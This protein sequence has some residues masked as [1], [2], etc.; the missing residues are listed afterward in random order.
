MTSSTTLRGYSTVARVLRLSDG[1]IL[2]WTLTDR[3]GA[4]HVFTKLDGWLGTPIRVDKNPMWQDG[5]HVGQL[6]R[7]GRPLTIAGFHRFCDA[8]NRADEAERLRR[9]ISGAFRS[10]QSGDGLV[11]VTEESTGISLEAHNVQLDGAPRFRVDGTDGDYMVTWE[12]PLF[13]GDPLLYE[14][15]QTPF[16]AQLYTP[17]AD[18]GLE[19]ALF[20]DADG[21]T[22]GFL[23][24]TGEKDVAVVPLTNWG[25]AVAYPQVTVQG[26]FPSGFRLVL[27]GDGPALRDGTRAPWEVTYRGEVLPS[28]EVTVDMS[29]MLLID[30]IDQSWAVSDPHW[31][32]VEPGG[33]V[34]GKL[35]GVAGGLGQATMTLTPAYI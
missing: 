21:V 2:D 31:G 17:G 3:P 9:A 16:L 25:N 18:S 24:F 19:Y 33:T 29:G 20:D 6:W 32:G 12:L 10:G 14:H 35:V 30:G 5:T 4:N 34:T 27:T 7:E 28:L 8:P 26:N 15:R 22:T 13:A 11:R 23:E 1:F